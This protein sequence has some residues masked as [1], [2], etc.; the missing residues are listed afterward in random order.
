MGQ[1]NSR[2]A[3]EDCGSYDNA[4][5]GERDDADSCGSST[6][7]VRVSPSTRA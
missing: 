4:Y 3:S 1:S 6:S 2:R 7:G 5:E